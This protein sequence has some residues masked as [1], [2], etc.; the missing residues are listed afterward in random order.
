M[1]LNWKKLKKELIRAGLFIF[2]IVLLFAPLFFNNLGP[3]LLYPN[4]KGPY[5]TWAGDPS[6]TMVISYET[7]RTVSTTVFWGT[8][9]STFNVNTTTNLRIHQINLTGLEPNTLYY[10][11][12]NS[13]EITCYYM[14]KYYSF[15]TG[16][17]QTEAGAFR[18][19][20]YGDNQLTTFGRSEHQ[21]IVDR[22]ATHDPD[23]IINTGDMVAD[24]SDLVNWDRLFYELRNL[25]SRKPFMASIGNHELYEG[26]IPDYGANFR[27]FFAYEGVEDYYSFNY[28]NVCFLALNVSTDEHRI[29]AAERTWLNETLFMANSSSDID[30]IIVYFHVPLYS[31]GG[32]GNNQHHI[33]DYAQI[34]KD[35]EVDIVF[36][37]HD[38]HYERMNIDGTHFF[39]NGG[40][41]GIL[42]FFLPWY[43]TRSWSQYKLIAY[44]YLII[45]VDGKNLNIQA[46]RVDG[47]VFDEIHLVSRRN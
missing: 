47:F 11:K 28:S 44:H 45:D 6:T 43:G 36:Q 15:R 17:N 10:Y 9:K 24:S 35:Y 46:I 32:H 14:N 38:H 19:A 16:L 29:T 13:T 40:G 27:K 7:P 8:N 12:I 18:F 3:W 21:R 2:I 22:V 30:W 34:L 33:D 5:L 1:A 26:N 39:V 25:A 20:V 4:E 37:G 23:F 41:G 31:S 42:D